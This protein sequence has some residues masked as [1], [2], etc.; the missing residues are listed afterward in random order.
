MLKSSFPVGLYKLS[1]V[2]FL[3]L[4]LSIR[5][6]PQDGAPVLTNSNVQHPRL[7]QT[8]TQGPCRLSLHSPRQLSPWSSPCP[9]Q[10]LWRITQQHSSLLP[11]LNATQS[12][13]LCMWGAL[14]ERRDAT[15]T[16]SSIIT[17][18]GRQVS[19]PFR[20]HKR[21]GLKKLERGQKEGVGD[22]PC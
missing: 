16:A 13:C 4:S 22:L 21:N 14:T 12:L 1:D 5:G 17:S 15:A 3:F 8:R 18:S 19:Y 10:Q 9:L 11:S 6:P 2:Y 20:L 7:P